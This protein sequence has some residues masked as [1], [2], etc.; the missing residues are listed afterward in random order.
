MNYN[1][2]LNRLYNNGHDTLGILY[3]FD[4]NDSLRYCWTLEDEYREV[5]KYGE[6]RIPAGQYE[7]RLRTEGGFYRRYCNHKNLAIR[8]LTKKYG[9]LQICDVPQYQYVLI[10]IGNDEDD[11]AGCILVGNEPKNNSMTKGWI[12]D[13]TI[14]Y[15]NLVSP[16]YKAIEAKRQI[17]INILDTDRDI[18]R[19]F[20]LI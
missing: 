14:A 12:S 16:I 7:V 5:K 2:L 3:F 15:V 20:K 13:S 10:H 18:L 9:M 6:T 8:E 19:Q 1:L 11:T 4:M 17:F